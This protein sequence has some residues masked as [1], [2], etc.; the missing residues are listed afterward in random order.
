MGKLARTITKAEAL[1]V[2]SPG[3]RSIVPVLAPS[4]RLKLQS[5]DGA[6]EL[7]PEQAER[8]HREF[9]R[10]SGHGL[11]SL[12]LDDVGSPLPPALAYWRQLANR[13][14]AAVCALPDI[15]D[16]IVKPAVPPL[17]DAEFETIAAAAPP[18]FGAEYVSPTVLGVLW[19]DIDSA[20]EDELGHSR[21]PFGTFLKSRSPAWNLV[22]RVHFNLAE[23]RKDEEAPFAFLA[24]YTTKL[25]AAAKAQHLPLGKALQEYAGTNDRDRL[26]SLLT[27]VQHA[28]ES[29]GWLQVMVEAGE[30]YQPLRWTSS[31]AMQLLRDV[32][33]LESAGVV[34]R[35]PSSWHM[36]RPSRPQVKTTV[37]AAAPSQLGLDAMLDFDLA[38]TLDGDELSAAEVNRLLAQ[39]D[40]LAFIRGKWVEVD[41]ERLSRTLEQFQAI[42]QR[43]ADDGLSFAEAMRLVAGAGIG[44]DA[45]RQAAA[46]DWSETLAGP[47]LSETL[48]EMRHPDRAARVDPG[49]ALNATLRPY[50]LAGLQW[51]HLLANLRL[52]ACLADDMGLGK[53]IQLISLLLVLKRERSDAAKRERRTSLLVA[54]ASLL[55]NWATEIERFAPGLKAVIAHPSA[56]ASDELKA[57][58][59]AALAEVDLVITSYGTLLRATGLASTS[60]R[61]AILDE[62]QTIKNPGAKQTKAVKQLDALSR[63]ALTGT[64]IEN[65]LGDLWSIFDFLNPGLLGSA[66]QFS[67]YVKQLGEGSASNS[68]GPLRELVRPYVLRRMKTD[69][70]IIADL[71][72]KTEVKAF[73]SL[74]RRQA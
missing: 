62:A 74:S 66:K 64:P 72:D 37:G 42:E 45:D 57:L 16:S 11:L 60:W 17:P 65:R 32:P 53:T 13:Y 9:A 48:S 58:G 20:L 27:P 18:M 63:I 59:G 6:A 46:A 44:G 22:G 40:G 7:P 56:M 10:G 2:A 26:L 61:L 4:G 36:G 71:P 49:S 15:A 5:A 30:I 50:Q 43:A 69:R 12:G 28:A 41:R 38:V 19:K 73:C 54:P 51:L 24:T 52:G 25:S 21:L 29:C 35:M 1:A 67:S 14:M 8:L 3:P 47:W 70:S 39:S 34:V 68:Y 33:A 31:E 55:S 23:N